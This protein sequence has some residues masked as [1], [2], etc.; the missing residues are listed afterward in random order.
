MHNHRLHDQ[1]VVVFV[2]LTGQLEKSLSSGAIHRM[3]VRRQ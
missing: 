1:F 3:R 2:V